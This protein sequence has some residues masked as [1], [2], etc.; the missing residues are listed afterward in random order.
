M[1]S[2]WFKILTTINERNVVFQARNATI[3]VEVENL[4]VLL[5]DLQFIRNRWDDILSECKLV[6]NEIKISSS[7]PPSRKRKRTTVFSDNVDE[8]STTA[9]C[10]NEEAE[11]KSNTFLAIVDSVVAGITNRFDAVRKLNDTFS[12]IHH[13]IFNI[14]RKRN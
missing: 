5:S 13:Q 14:N 1:S 7:F 3:D 4:N 8:D 2:I 11:F 9:S 10:T 6:A 12:F